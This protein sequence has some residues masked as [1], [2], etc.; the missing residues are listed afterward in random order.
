MQ[1]WVPYASIKNR[2]P[3]IGYDLRTILSGRFVMVNS[4]CAGFN[5]INK[6][7]AL[8]TNEIACDDP[9][10]L[11]IRWLDDKTF[12]TKSTR[13]YNEHCHPSIDLYKVISFDGRLLTLK[14]IW[15]GWS[16]L[17]DNIDSQDYMLQLIKKG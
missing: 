11:L 12:M 9:D 17:E 2:P 16:K 5:F 14:R 3:G 15:T 8:W 1:A 7:I 10:T 4:K 6:K 13:R